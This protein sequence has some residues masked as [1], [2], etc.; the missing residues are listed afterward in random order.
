MTRFHVCD[1]AVA[2]FVTS[3]CMCSCKHPGQSALK[4][5][6]RVRSGG[7]ACVYVCL[8]RK[9]FSLFVCLAP[10]CFR[11]VILSLFLRLSLLR[12]LLSLLLFDVFAFRCT[13]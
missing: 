2:L 10:F 7:S 8:M 11:F 4:I 1:I 12:L 3:V 5:A 13:Y 9:A 6:R